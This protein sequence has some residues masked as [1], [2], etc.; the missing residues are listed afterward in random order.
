M[1]NENE[2]EIVPV[3][4]VNTG[5]IVLPRNVRA[6]I[7]AGGMF[8]SIRGGDTTAN[9]V[10]VF[11]AMSDASR[12]SEEIGTPIEVAG[13][14]VRPTQME[15]PVTGEL[16]DSVMTVLVDTQG[17]G[18][19]SHGKGVLSAVGN[20]LGTFGEPDQWPQGMKVVPIEQTGRRG[21]KYTTLK[22]AF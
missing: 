11:N 17:N 13:V 15:D 3:V 12:L 5:G 14:V 20:I 4:E 9:K 7:E 22:I 10:A 18:H 2:M 8:C 19:M 6:G 21:F 1:M 16:V